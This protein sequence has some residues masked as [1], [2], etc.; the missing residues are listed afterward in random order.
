MELSE[1]LDSMT[2]E[3]R[4]EFLKEMFKGLRKEDK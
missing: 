1:K 3:E 2:P 4:E